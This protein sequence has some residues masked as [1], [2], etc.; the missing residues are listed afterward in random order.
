[1][2]LKADA[3]PSAAPGGPPGIAG[4]EGF[5]LA[6]AAIMVAVVIGGFLNLW[7]QGVTSFAAPWP[8]HVH[9]VVFMG[10]VGLFALQ[11][12]LATRGPLALHRR[13]GWIAV[14]WI[15]LLLVVGTA[16]IVRVMR[17]GT[18]P[19]MWTPAYFLVM[20]MMALVAFAILTAA[21]IRLRRETA[22]HRRLIFCGMAA[23][24]ITPVNRLMPVAVLFAVMSLASAVAILLFPLAGM[25]SD[26]RRTGRVHPAWAWGL[27]ALVLSGLA[28]EL[29]GR[30]A[31]AGAAVTSLA[32]G[33]PG[34]D[35]PP[36]A[37]PGL[38]PPPIAKA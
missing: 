22:W 16:T 11:V 7:L 34:A 33:T 38:G 9:A 6:A 5:F 1:M 10:W 30:S 27:G 17:L 14:A 35:R 18:T 8:V 20:N 36:L 24:A 25:L 13:L 26:W 15:P 4:D 19:P 37:W 31:F 12:W 29:I 2:P 23:L 3:L 28:T 32:A 21:A